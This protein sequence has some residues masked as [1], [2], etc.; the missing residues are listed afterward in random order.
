[1]I[2]KF[3]SGH[4]RPA[5]AGPNEYYCRSTR[6]RNHSTLRVLAMKRTKWKSTISI[7]YYKVNRCL[8]RYSPR[9]TTTNQMSRQGLAQ[10]EQ[11]C[12]FR[13]KFGPKLAFLVNL[14]QAMQAYSMPCC[15]SIGGCGA[16]AVSRK[17]PI[18][19]ITILHG[20]V[21]KILTILQF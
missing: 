5:V 19:Y 21:V 16:R 17:T 11:K 15:G 10:N 20:G 8:A 2:R 4:H 6:N 13:T 7:I 14:G 18:Y 1:M 9:A 3:G 12:H